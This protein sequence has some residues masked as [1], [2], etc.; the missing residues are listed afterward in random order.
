RLF[1]QHPTINDELPNRILSGT[2]QVKPN[3]RRFQGSSVEFDDGSVAEDVD[4]VVFATGY[5]FSFPFLAS[6]VVSV[7]ENKTSL[8]KYVFPPELEH[9]T[10]AIIGLVQPL[11]AI[12]PISEMQARWATRV[13]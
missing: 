11:G 9:P 12:M 4:L 1:S 5:R 13:F 8:Y 10:L 7:S 3:I 6:H 2:V